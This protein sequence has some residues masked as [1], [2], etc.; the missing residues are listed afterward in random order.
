[1]TLLEKEISFEG[2]SY[3]VCELSGEIHLY[4]ANH[5]QYKTASEFQMGI[6]QLVRSTSVKDE[7]G[8]RKIS[9]E[10]FKTFPHRLI[11]RL[12]KAFGVLLSDGESVISN[13]AK[14]LQANCN[15]PSDVDKWLENWIKADSGE[16]PL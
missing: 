2:K 15:P 7:T 12:Q 10:E 13:A 5:P 3:K 6:I 11:S 14:L 8:W 4:L 16:N 9:E 1:M